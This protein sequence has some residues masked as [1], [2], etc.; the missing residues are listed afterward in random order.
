VNS[1]QAAALVAAGRIL[2]SRN[3]TGGGIRIKAQAGETYPQAVARIIDT[4]DGGDREQ[5][6]G[7]V[8]WVLDYDRHDRSP[9]TA[10]TSPKG[11]PEDPA[12]DL[13]RR[14]AERASGRLK[15]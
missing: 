14:Q 8:A 9:A 2:Q 7:L 13:P 4:L 15:A 3:W 5:L 10:G 12:F 1:N 11:A 6:R